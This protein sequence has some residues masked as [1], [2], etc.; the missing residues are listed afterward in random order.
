[1][2]NAPMSVR[3]GW[4]ALIGPAMVMGKCLVAEI[5]ASPWCEDER[6]FAYDIN[7]LVTGGRGH[8]EEWISH[9]FGKPVGKD[10]TREEQ[11]TAKTGIEKSTGMTALLSSDFFLQTS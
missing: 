4:E 5:G 6:R 11:Q 10:N 8:I 2:S 3:M 7:M 9:K 1:M